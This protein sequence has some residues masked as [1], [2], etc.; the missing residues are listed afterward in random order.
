MNY[1][2]GTVKHNVSEYTDDFRSYET[3]DG[4]EHGTVCH[5]VGEYVDGQIHVNGMESFWSMLKRAHK[6]TYHKMSKKHLGRSVQE[7][8]GRH[9]IREHDTINQMQEVVAGMIGKRLM[10]SDLVGNG[11]VLLFWSPSQ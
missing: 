5:S 8:A 7:F 10:Y 11:D 4:Y 6:G 9:N 3:L 2:H 1:E